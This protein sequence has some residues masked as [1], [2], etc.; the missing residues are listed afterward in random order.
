MYSPLALPEKERHTLCNYDELYQ[1][2][3]SFNLKDGNTRHR[4]G[5]T[6]HKRS[7]ITHLEAQQEEEEEDGEDGE[8]GDKADMGHV[9]DTVDVDD[10]EQKQE[11]EAQIGSDHF[12]LLWI[13]L[14][15]LQG[16]DMIAT[17]FDIHDLVVTGE[18]TQDA[19]SDTP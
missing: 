12:T 5:T 8:D 4:S 15:S 13:N 3:S 16:V 18:P 19:L 14:L 1:F 10:E 2:L 17:H 7:V 9:N 6:T 11:E